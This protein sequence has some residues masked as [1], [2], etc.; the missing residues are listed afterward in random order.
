MTWR[1]SELR[2]IDESE[3]V[4]AVL[5]QWELAARIAA[6]DASVA[7]EADKEHLVRQGYPLGACPNQPPT[8]DEIEAIIARTDTAIANGDTIAQ[9]WLRIRTHLLAALVAEG[10]EQIY[11]QGEVPPTVRQPRHNEREPMKLPPIDMV[12][13]AARDN[14]LLHEEA[15]ESQSSDIDVLPLT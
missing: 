4:R 7:S 10:G 5:A 1:P 14:G 8:R 6:R 15:N 11:E 13:Q 2:P 3:F 9:A 12:T